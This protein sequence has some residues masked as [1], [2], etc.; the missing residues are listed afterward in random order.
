MSIKRLLDAVERRDD[1][2]RWVAAFA[3][4]IPNGPRVTSS[5]TGKLGLREPGQHASSPNLASRDNVVHGLT[6]F[7]ATTGS[8]QAN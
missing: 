5:F 6:I 7:E 3:L 8:L 4:P 1:I 2:S